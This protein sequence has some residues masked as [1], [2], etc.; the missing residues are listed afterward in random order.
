MDEQL[1]YLK[2][3]G[4]DKQLKKLNK[5]LK[6]KTVVIYGAG[7]LFK[8]VQKNYDLSNLNIIG[9]S[10]RKYMTSPEGET[11]LG[12][13]VISPDKITEYNPDY[14]LISTLKFLEI[15]KDFRENTFKGTKTKVLP[16]ID[17]P[18]FT[19]LKEVFE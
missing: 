3:A 16:L 18:F 17:K 4:F 2:K 19:L 9:I 15:L 6:N 12:Y 13:R 5:K 11:D 10:D 14:V 7:I 1:E 8:K